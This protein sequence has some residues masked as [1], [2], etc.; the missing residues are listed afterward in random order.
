MKKASGR[1]NGD[2]ETHTRGG[3]QKKKNKKTNSNDD[4]FCRRRLCFHL[5]AL[6]IRFSVLKQSQILSISK[7]KRHDVHL[8]NGN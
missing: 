3:E 6:R 8:M 5:M 7:G 4:F 1:G 2:K